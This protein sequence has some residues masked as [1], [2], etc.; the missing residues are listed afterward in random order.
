MIP[1]APTLFT[2]QEVAQSLRVHS[3]TVYSLIHQGE[4][5]AVKVGTQWRVPES[6]L[7]GF[8]ERG[9]PGQVRAQETKG[10]GRRPAQAAFGLVGGRGDIEMN[11]G[12]SDALGEV[13]TTIALANDFGQDIGFTG[14][15]A[16]ENSHYDEKKGVLTNEKVFRNEEGAIAYGL[17]SAAGES[18]ERRAYLIEEEREGMRVIS[19]GKTSLPAYTDELLQ[20]LALALDAQDHGEPEVE[21]GHI[22]GA[23]KAVNG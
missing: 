17:V 19:N 6:A 10:Q 15:L 22:L 13:Q 11:D 7:Y 14:S 12:K 23:L 4:L 1:G 20:L 18:K 8:I 2:V 3:R 21:C 9:G 16:A 5:K